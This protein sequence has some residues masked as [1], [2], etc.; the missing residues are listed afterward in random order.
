MVVGCSDIC[1]VSTICVVNNCFKGHLNY[2]FDFD[3]FPGN[4]PFMALFNKCS[5]GSGLL[6]IKLTQA[7]SIFSK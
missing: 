7:K 1:R 4:D 2:F 3:Q 5:N 6:H